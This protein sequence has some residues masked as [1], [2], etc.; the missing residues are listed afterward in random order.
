MSVSVTTSYGRGRESWAN[1]APGSAEAVLHLL[2]PPREAL[3]G[4][5]VEVRRTL[6]GADGR[7][8]VWDVRFWPLRGDD[9]VAGLLGT[10]RAAAVVAGQPVKIAG[11]I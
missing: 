7:P 9:G 11:E 2:S 10:V 6:A 1:A 8:R 5:A 3:E 4:R